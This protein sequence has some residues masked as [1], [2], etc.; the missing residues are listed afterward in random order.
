MDAIPRPGQSS[1]ERSDCGP[2]ATLLS[3][4]VPQLSA[5]SN[6]GTIANDGRILLLS[7]DEPEEIEWQLL[8]NWTMLLPGAKK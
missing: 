7:T 8:S 6:I 5:Y 4:G 3:P 2:P 1:P